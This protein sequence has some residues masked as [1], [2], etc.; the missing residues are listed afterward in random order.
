SAPPPSELLEDSPTIVWRPLDAVPAG[1]AAGPVA[2]PEPAAVIAPTAGS[3]PAADPSADASAPRIRFLLEGEA[4]GT[5][6]DAAERRREAARRGNRRVALV[7]ALGV[8]ITLI[9]AIAPLIGAD[10]DRSEAGMLN[11]VGPAPAAGAAA[12]SA[13]ADR[14]PAR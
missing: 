10:D 11:P 12:G 9:G 14:E 1:M 4:Q 6:V 13:P 3:G 5:T 8:F 2:V 7:V